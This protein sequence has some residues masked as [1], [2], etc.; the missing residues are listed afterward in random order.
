MT[1]EGIEI[2]VDGD[3]DLVVPTSPLLSPGLCPS[4]IVIEPQVLLIETYSG[5]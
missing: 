3:R 4:G 5:V 1:A 2:E